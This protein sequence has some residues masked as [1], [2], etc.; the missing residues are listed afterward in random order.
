[1]QPQSWPEPDPQ[2]AAAIR[3]MYRGRREAPL[4]VQVR[5]R[6]GEL[7]PDA[8]FADAFG[9]V[10]KPGWSPGRL[11]LVTVLQKAA[12]LTDRQAADEVRE[13]IAW[14][15]A[16]GLNLEDP[17]FDHSVLSEFRSR[18]VAHGLEERVL[19][20]LLERLQTLDLGAGGRQS[21]HRLHAH[22][23][24]G[25]RSEPT[26][27]GRRE[28]P[29][30]PERAGRR[31]PRMG[32]SGAGGG[33]LEPPLR[34]PDR[35]LATARIQDQAEP[36]RARLRRRRLHA[37]AGRLRAHVCGVA[38]RAARGTDP[39]VRA[40]A[41]LHPHHR[42]GRQAADPAARADRGRRRR[43]AARPGPRGLSLR[44]RHSLVRQA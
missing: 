36:T 25:A 14:K 44:H 7:F 37:A 12:N 24:R 40:G 18:V 9:Q 15:Y 41:E 39:T 4:A 21:T 43:P 11:A 22:R 31:M 27:V 38:A 17:G 32:R 34:G 26:R 19:D 23:R 28:R 42:P 5:D 3:V 8:A 10:G 1:M 6:L 20:L 29:R 30:G 33:G 2:V 13:N 16:L 35:Q